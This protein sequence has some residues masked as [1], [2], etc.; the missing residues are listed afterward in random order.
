MNDAST[1]HTYREILSQ[2]AAWDE[3]VRVVM[4]H[5][6]PI[7]AL[8]AQGIDRVL[9]TGCGSSYYLAQAAAALTQQLTGVAASAVP[10]SEFLLYPD[11]VF[12][13]PAGRTALIVASRSGVTSEAL[14]AVEVFRKGAQGPVIAITDYPDVPLA[15]MG[16]VN[17]VLPA[18]QEESIAQTR[19]FAANYVAAV[20]VGMVFAGRDDLLAALAQLP[21]VGERLIAAV[22]E[23][24]EALAQDRSLTRCF[25][26]GSGPRYGLA[27]EVSLKMK[28][29]ALS[30]SEPFHFMEFRHGPI[31]MVNDNALVVGLISEASRAQEEAVLAECAAL[32]GHTLTLAERGADITFESG[33]PEEA[34][35]VLYLPALQ[36]LAYYRAAAA[37]LDPDRPTH[38]VTAVTLDLPPA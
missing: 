16:D 15:T 22:R 14:R 35:G 13:R 1:P 9:V 11:A 18:A 21:P 34:R 33:L 29:M 31:S 32:G 10:S 24:V 27:S 7:A 8:W 23:R 30:V 37:G 2:A 20:A 17:L 5:R 36:L 26:L 38:L 4:A 6:E 3:S 19:S 28:E 25:F 12:V